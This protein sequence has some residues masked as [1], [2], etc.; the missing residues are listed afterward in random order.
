M[1]DFALLASQARDN[2]KGGIEHQVGSKVDVEGYKAVGVVKYYG[3]HLTKTGK[4]VYGIELDKPIGKNNVRTSMSLF[5]RTP[6]V[7]TL[8]ISNSLTGVTG[9]TLSLSLPLSL[10]ALYTIFSSL[11]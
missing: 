3:P 5:A 7:L 10:E 9:F 1:A 8:G 2:R 11:V 6:H 4:V